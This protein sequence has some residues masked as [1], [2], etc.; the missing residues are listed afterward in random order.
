M[1]RD[2]WTTDDEPSDPPCPTFAIIELMF[3]RREVSRRTFTWMGLDSAP[4]F[5]RLQRYLARLALSQSGEIVRLHVE[6]SGLLQPL[7]LRF[8]EDRPTI[9]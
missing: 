9:H 6:S 5:P 7:D 2:D 3:V 1:E 4:Y 8:D